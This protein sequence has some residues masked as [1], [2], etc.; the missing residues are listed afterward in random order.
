MRF[1]GVTAVLAVGAGAWAS[2]GSIAKRVVVVC[3][4]P[5]AHAA[6]I[7]PGREVAAQLLTQAGVRLEWRN[8]ER[9]CV[10]TGNGIVVAVSFATPEDRHPGAFAY[11][12]PFERTR[13]V[14]FYDRV[15]KAADPAIMPCLLGHVL[16]HE[17]VHMLQGLSSHSA[18]GIMKPHWDQRDYAEM[19]RG[20]FNFT[21]DD[22]LKIHEG[23][24]RP[25]Q[26]APVE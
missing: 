11:A 23:L 20:Q 19:R 7:N 2:D 21:E 26:P 1:L 9:F 4:N 14:L 10:A 22:I 12:M 15:R 8:D 6:T 13:I 25:S 17:I 3:L 5:A 24:D 16:A 18:G